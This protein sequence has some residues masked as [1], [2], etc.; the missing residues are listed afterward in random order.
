MACTALFML[1]TPA[2][3]QSKPAP[4]I[5]VLDVVSS[6]FSVRVSR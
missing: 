3:P 6:G 4:H 2:L 5:D 1:V